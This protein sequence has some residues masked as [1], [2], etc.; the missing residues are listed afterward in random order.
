MNAQ[1]KVI[2]HNFFLFAFVKVAKNASIEITKPHDPDRKA[3]TIVGEHTHIHTDAHKM[4]VL[5]S[6]AVSRRAEYTRHSIKDGDDRQC[7]VHL[8]L[9]IQ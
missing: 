6:R 2:N 5:R 3:T 1:K 7:S 4:N 8:L 9:C